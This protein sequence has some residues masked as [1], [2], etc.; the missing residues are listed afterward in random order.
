MCVQ[1]SET[2]RLSQSVADLASQVDE[3]RAQNTKTHALLTTLIAFLN[4]NKEEKEITE[5]E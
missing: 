4:T 2:E 1:M 3:L 5:E